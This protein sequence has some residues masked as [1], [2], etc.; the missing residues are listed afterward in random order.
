[1]SM[2]RTPFFLTMSVAGVLAIATTAEADQVAYVSSLVEDSIVRLHDDNGDGD[3]NDADESAVFFGPGNESGFP[4]VGSAQSIL[5]LGIDHVLAADGEESGEFETRVYELRDLNGDGDAMDAGEAT[6]FWDS[7]LPPPFD[8]NFD[9]PKDMMIGPDGAIY[10]ADNNTINFD[11]DTP[12]AVWRL[13]DLNDDG[14]VNDDGEVTLYVELSPPGEAFGFISEDFK[15][16]AAGRI[17]F[18][19]LESSSNTGTV[20]I[21]DQAQNITQF[22]S[23]DDLFGVVLK[24]TGMALQP[25]RENPVFAA[26]DVFEIL[27]IVELIDYNENGVIDDND[28]RYDWYRNDFAVEPLNWD[29][30]QVMDVDYAPDGSLW[31]LDMANESILRFIDLNGDEDFMDVGEAMQIYDSAEAGQAGG[32]VM[33]FPRTVGF[34]ALDVPGDIT[35]DGTVDVSDLLALLAAWGDCPD[36]PA[37][38]PADLDESGAV[39]VSD[40]LELLAAWS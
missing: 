5:V 9:R 3:F 25:Q 39:D 18:S 30:N 35:G 20:F 14:D 24:E 26:T 23:E 10:L 40:L 1:M 7:I 8:V 27:R 12:E 32:F 16:D 37:E 36:P 6:V 15:F 34:A 17:L 19:N 21:I 33:T 13:E 4:G 2:N 29:H 22:A 31:L 38:C 28:E 11:G